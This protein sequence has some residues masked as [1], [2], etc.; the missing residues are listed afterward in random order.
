MLEFMRVTC[1]FGSNEHRPGSAYLLN[2]HSAEIVS[3]LEL[4]K[5]KKKKKMV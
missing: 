5:K 4:R 2:F 3:V 1:S